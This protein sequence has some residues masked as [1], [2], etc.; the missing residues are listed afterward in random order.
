VEQSQAKRAAGEQAN[1]PVKAPVKEEQQDKQPKAPSP[2][3]YLDTTDAM[4]RKIFIGSTTSVNT[5]SFGFPYQGAQLGT[6]HIRRSR[7]G[8]DVYFQIEKGQMLCGIDHC[9]INVKFDNGPIQS[10]TASPAADHDSTML[11]IGNATRFID[12]MWDAKM[13]R[14]EAL[15]YQEGKQTLEFNVEGFEFPD[16]PKDKP[17][18]PAAKPVK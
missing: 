4:G 14:I 17:K 9:T 1:E 16:T 11:F 7:G 18:S 13:V 8:E 2:W 12:A 10:Y 6:L 15:Y 5:L 3:K